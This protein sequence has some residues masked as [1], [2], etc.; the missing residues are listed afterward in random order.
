V[1]N[2]KHSGEAEAGEET[3]RMNPDSQSTARQNHRKAPTIKE[4]KAYWAAGRETHEAEVMMEQYKTKDALTGGD[5]YYIP[6]RDEKG[7]EKA[8]PIDLTG[9]VFDDE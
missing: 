5:V 8:A 4:V 2:R 9:Q 1:A 7:E 6:E 3:G